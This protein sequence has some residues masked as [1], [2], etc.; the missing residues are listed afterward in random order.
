MG[1]AIGIDLGTTNSVVAYKDTTV[2]V[3]QTGANNEDLCR[4]CVALDK[5]GQF[6]VGNATYKNW[7]RLTPNI[8]V[9]VKRLMGTGISDPQVQKMRADSKSYPYGI[10]K[11]T[12]GTDEAVAIVLQ[13]KEYTP[14]Q[15]SG[16]I[17]KAL[18]NDANNK[19]GDV[20]HAVITVPA[21]FTEKQKSATKKAAELAGIRVQRLLAEPTAAAISYGFDKMMP[22]E[23]KQVLVYDFGGGTFDL[24]ILIAV[25][26]QFIESGSGG[27]RW[28]GGDDIDRI[29]SDYAC[30][31][32]EKRDGFTLSEL[33][34]D[35]SEKEKS[36]FIAGL[37][38]GVEEAKKTL[39]QVDKATIFFSD[40]LENEDDEPVDDLIISRST[41]ESLI[42]P[43]I[44][45]TIDLIEDLVSKTGIPM[46][47]IDN[48]LLVGGSSCIP[49]VKRMLSD[50]YGSEKVLSSEK[51]MLAIAEGAAILAHALPSDEEALSTKEVDPESQ[52]GVVLTTKHQTLIQLENPDG[53]HHMEK[54]IESQEVLPFEA[55]RKFRTVSNNQKIVEV[56]LFTDAENN[57]FT[58][59]ASGFFTISD[60]L[61]AMSELN[62]TFNLDEDETM[63]ARVKIVKTG[64]VTE[65]R[66]GRGRNDSSCLSELSQ[67]LEEVIANPQISDSKKATFISEMQQIID[68]INSN[69]YPPTDSRWSDHEEEIRAAYTRALMGDKQENNL[70]E[71]FATILIG[72]FSRFLNNADE[73]EMRD[74]LFRLQNSSDNFEKESIR[75]ELE[76]T[77][78]RYSLLIHVFLF[79]LIGDKSTNP[80]VA[81]RA[82]CV[83]DEMVAALDNHNIGEVNELIRNN[84]D[85]LEAIQTEG[86]NIGMGTGLA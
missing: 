73:N 62:F 9:S 5:S 42:T 25:D 3:I 55:N 32:I 69:N 71:I 30:K 35:K 4:S 13:G 7:K 6:L 48:I 2:K 68:T 82:V 19:L 10:K 37:K 21:Y 16:E 84:Q 22:G 46:D 61:P 28:L 54:I 63:T 44:Q 59:T 51:P 78:N 41:F 23:S 43:L 47:T 67:K 33:L 66:L 36:A 17:L 64:K 45:R 38:F 76:S 77:A 75:Q 65:I 11:P 50:K 20:S 29:L 53:T 24:S 14:E 18:K 8:V 27:D 83:Y 86:I 79:K 72:Q 80:Q 81:G 70:G 31:E 52:I 85:L 58:K 60:N 12:G 15:I 1:K 56:R 74:K 57:S 49:L 26:G 40:F 34:D 39:S